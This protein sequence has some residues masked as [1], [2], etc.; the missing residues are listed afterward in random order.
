MSFRPKL[1]KFEPDEAG[2]SRR[3]FTD[4]KGRPYVA[5]R[6]HYELPRACW[7]WRVSAIAH[8]GFEGTFDTLAEL[9]DWFTV[10]DDE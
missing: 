5:T 8:D 10:E 3:R 6:K 2:H 7:A 1:K 9:R 4:H